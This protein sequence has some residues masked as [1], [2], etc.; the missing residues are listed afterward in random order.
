MTKLPPISAR[1][2]KDPVNPSLAKPLRVIATTGSVL[3]DGCCPI[4]KFTLNNDGL[5]RSEVVLD[6]GQAEGGRPIFEILVNSSTCE[7]V[8][9]QTTYS[10][11]R[12]EVSHDN[13]D[14]P[15]L[16]F[17]NAMDTYRTVTHK[18]AL[19]GSVQRIRS[20]YAQRSQRYQ[21]IRFLTPDSSVTFTNIGFERILPEAK[22]PGSFHCSDQTLNH[23]WQQ[24][25]RTVDMCTVQA[26]ET[27][28]AWDVTPEGTRV[29]GQ[30]WAPCRHGTR[31]CDKIVCFEVKIE[32]IGASWGV[33]MVANGLVFCLDRQKG[34]L[35]AHEGLSHESSVFASSAKGS[36]EISPEMLR[37]EWLTVQTV[38]EGATASVSLNGVHVASLDHLNIHP[39]LGGSENNSGSVAF[40]GPAGWCATYCHLSVTDLNGKMLYANSMQLTEIERTLTDFGVGTN[41]LPCLIDG[42]KRDRSTFGGDLHIS[43][44]SVAYSTADFDTVR[45]SIELLTSHQTE[46]GYLGTLCPIQAPVHDSDDEPPT[47]AFYSLTYALLLT[48]AIKDYWLY[49]GDRTTVDK[50][51]NALLRLVAFTERFHND[52]GLI[53]APPPLSCR[54]LARF[55]PTY[56]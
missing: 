6:Y 54:L 51:W 19:T 32:E 44:R 30:H 34:L 28:P 48:V 13:G 10:E 21:R 3:L 37:A 33:H 11:T 20:R 46:D 14:G 35:T 18:V 43:G 42:A 47:Y 15:F 16:L 40:G 41:K 9:F 12:R 39:I 31:W 17:S 53:A 24:G 55:Y 49:S 26:G 29:R 1:R 2:A 7:T 23:I 56:R 8:S 45:G 25:V 36:W 52:I 5:N 27:E 50:T 4:D 22:F 38:A